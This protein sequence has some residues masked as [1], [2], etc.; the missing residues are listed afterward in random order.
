MRGD[1]FAPGVWTMPLAFFSVTYATIPII[2]R[3]SIRSE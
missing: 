1:Y 3:L 2:S